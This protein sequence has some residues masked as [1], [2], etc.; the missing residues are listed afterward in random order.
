MDKSKYNMSEYDCSI[1]KKNMTEA[2]SISQKLSVVFEDIEDYESY[3]SVQ[4]VIKCCYN[5]MSSIINIDE[6]IKMDSYYPQRVNLSRI[7]EDIVSA[8]RSKLRH[9]GVKIL[10][11]CGENIIAMTDADRFVSALMN[12]IINS[13]QNT[14]RGNGEVKIKVIVLG[15]NISVSVSDNGYGL[16]RDEITECIESDEACGLKVV[17]EF[18]R[19]A[20]TKLF[21]DVSADGGL[22]VSFRLPAASEGEII[23]KSPKAFISTGSL[24]AVSIYLSKIEDSVID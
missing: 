17:S 24:S 14:E 20:G 16:D 7:I 12:L 9:C 11:D 5:V 23:L 6:L 8:C 2:L 3:D 21:T 19:V 15:E 1:I 10:C 4:R 22:L 18:C 13:V